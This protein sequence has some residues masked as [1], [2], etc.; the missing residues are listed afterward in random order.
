M[1]R[2]HA[3][4]SG[5]SM[6]A[7]REAGIRLG[8]IKNGEQPRRW[9]S[10]GVGRENTMRTTNFDL[11]P[12]DDREFWCRLSEL[13]SEAAGRCRRRNERRKAAWFNRQADRA[14]QWASASDLTT[15]HE[16]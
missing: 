7:T 13:A 15:R 9:A 5:P 3:T 10:A 11:H 4:F 8:S 1:S 12:P 6:N 16:A 2:T 14:L